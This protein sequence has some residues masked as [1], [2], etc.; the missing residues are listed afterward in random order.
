MKIEIEAASILRL[1]GLKP[2]LQLDQYSNGPLFIE[3]V[4]RYVNVAV[5]AAL[6]DDERQADLNRELEWYNESW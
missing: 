2:D 3:R 1:H 6:A 5:R 4:T